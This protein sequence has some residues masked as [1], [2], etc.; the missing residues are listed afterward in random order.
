MAGIGAIT[1]DNAG[2][3]TAPT[4]LPFSLPTADTT[5]VSDHA[6]NSM[7]IMPAE[8]GVM[9][10]N[11]VDPVRHHVTSVLG[12]G[13]LAPATALTAAPSGV[14]ASTRLDCNSN[15]IADGDVIALISSLNFIYFR[16]ALSSTPLFDEVLIGGNNTNALAN[17]K[18][19]LN[20]TGVEGT[21]Y[22]YAGGSN[23]WS[24]YVTAGTVGSDD[25]TITANATGTAGNGYV[26]TFTGTAGIQF[27]QE[28][29]SVAQTAFSGGTAGTSSSLGAGTYQ[30]AYAYVREDDGAISGLSPTDEA[31]SGESQQIN[32]T[33]M[34]ASGDATVDYNR[35]YRTT[36]GGGRFYRV[37]DVA[38]ATTTYS[39]NVTDDTMTAFGASAYDERLYRAHRAGVAP[40]ARY[41]AMYRGRVFGGGALLSAP[42]SMGTVTVNTGT[43]VATFTNGRARRSMIG[44]R[45]QMTAEAQTFQI[46]DVD[47]SANTA[48]LDK[49][50]D[51]TLANQ[52]YVI[53]DN[54]DPYEVFWSEPGLPNNWPVTNSLKG[55][56][57]RDGKGITGLYAAFE[58]L[59]VFTR[60]AVWRLSGTGPLFSVSLVTDKCGCVSGHT[61]VMDGERMYWLGVDGVYGWDGSGEPVSMSSPQPTDAAVRG[62]DSTLARLSLGH[63]HRA[64][65]IH[66]EHDDEIRWYVPLDGESTNRYALVLDMQ[67]GAF[68]LDTCEDVTWAAIVQGYDGEDHSVTGDIQGVLMETALSNS[69]G[70]FGFEPTQAV[71][72]SSTRTVTV[73]G[74]PFPTTGNG[75][76]GVPVWHFAADGT[77]TRACI[78][79]NTSAIL[80]YRRYVTA[81]SAATQFSV[82]GILMWLQTGRFDLGERRLKKR[83]AGMTVAHSPDA[84]GQYWFFS[85]YNQTDFA[86]PTRGWAVGDLTDTGA[87]RR[88]IVAKDAMLHGWG[89]MAVEP[90]CDP[91]FSGITMEVASRDELDL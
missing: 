90:G 54:R 73:S 45:F 14:A 80:T 61:V 11:G 12:T 20:G 66:D 3:V 81:P 53:E 87:R 35:V 65:G 26:C 51:G 49:T 57:S 16:T 22:K 75:L 62:I 13:L 69:D 19:M 63:A 21:D 4:A 44:R 46:V 17:L 64:V 84:D 47:E 25:L 15:N 42:Y 60:Q 78:A 34:T 82:G 77:P 55:V 24:A 70:A 71:S 72:S 74:T 18:K 68:S 23:V 30:Y 6:L 86:L 83:L 31:V 1:L 8:R 33:G 52:A 59:I 5:R 40:K 79:S 85:A 50:R 91:T 89:L 56:I 67:T 37:D 28:S 36:T 39:D 10:A 29:V 27:E 41:L 48:T 7:V 9:W 76:V 38:A 32:I 58:S 88:Y 43:R 2:S